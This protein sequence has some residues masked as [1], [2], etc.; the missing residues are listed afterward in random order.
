MIVAV[1]IVAVIIVAVI[2]VA[3]II[4]VGTKL[5]ER[6]MKQHSRIT[7]TSKRGVTSRD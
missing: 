1:I 3:L 7:E 2:I 6:E 5:H 4:V